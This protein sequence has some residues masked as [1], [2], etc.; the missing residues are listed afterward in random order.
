MTKEDIELI[1]E[2]IDFYNL[3]HFKGNG[4]K[5]RLV[6]LKTELKAL[7][8]RIV[9]VELPTKEKLSFVDWLNKY[10]KGTLN[11]YVYEG[12]THSSLQIINKYAQYIK[13]NL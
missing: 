9:G 1:E 7:N 10:V 11:E 13:D 4:T 5:N 6:S 12:V 3:N 2:A 8:M